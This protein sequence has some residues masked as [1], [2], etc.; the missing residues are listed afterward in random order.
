MVRMVKTYLDF[1]RWNS[2][3]SQ[4]VPDAE[5]LFEA[6]G[7]DRGSGGGVNGQSRN[8]NYWYRRSRGRKRGAA[9]EQ[10]LPA[11]AKHDGSLTKFIEDTLKTSRV[12][13]DERVSV[14]SLDEDAGWR[15]DHNDNTMGPKEIIGW[16]KMGKY[17]FTLH[18]YHLCRA[19]T[20][21]KRA[22]LPGRLPRDPLGRSW[23]ARAL[24]SSLRG[25]DTDDAGR[26]LQRTLPAELLDAAGR[27][28]GG[29]SLVF[30]MLAAAALVSMAGVVVGV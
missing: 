20:A 2:S 15:C 23:W 8:A 9:P 16:G 7:I 19:L 30:G 27:E 1:T 6:G 4:R 22:L 12:D 14:L 28:G 21:I 11:L 24:G 13:E 17:D 25:R 5:I 3:W 18:N 10:Y 29:S 26:K